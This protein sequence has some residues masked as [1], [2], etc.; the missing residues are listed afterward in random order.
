MTS[1]TIT[2]LWL[3][4]VVCRRSRASVA[5][6][7]AESNPK[8]SMVP[9]RS[10]SIVFGTPTTGTPRSN[11]CWAMLKEPSPPMLTSPRM[12]NFFRPALTPSISSWGRRRVSPWPTLAEKRP[13]LAVPR[14]VPPR[15]SRRAE[16]LVIEGEK[17]LGFQDAVVAAE[18]TDWFPSRVWRPPWPRPG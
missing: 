17:P 5:Q 10:L 2:R 7:T 12:F 4:A 6:A 15:V 16:F 1:S 9:S 14:M 18:E 11:N 8:V 13:R 3:S